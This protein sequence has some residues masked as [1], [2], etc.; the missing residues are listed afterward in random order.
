MLYSPK[1]HSWHPISLLLFSQETGVL[2]K[3]E[4]PPFRIHLSILCTIYVCY[5][6]LTIFFPV[7][8]EF[9]YLTNTNSS[10][11]VL[12]N[13]IIVNSTQN[14]LHILKPF[15]LFPFLLSWFPS[16]KKKKNR[17]KNKKQKKK[18]VF[19]FLSFEVQ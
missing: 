8:L 17:T 15:F 11:P 2:R 12:S 3:L 10:R 9:S 1:D 16:P 4:R 7:L 18:N 6:V 14:S 19:D 13:S 5:N